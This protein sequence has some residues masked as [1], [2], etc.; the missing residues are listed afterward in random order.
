MGAVITPLLLM[1][2]VR[3]IEV[4]SLAQAQAARRWQPQAEIQVL[5]LQGSGL[6]LLR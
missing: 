2:K 5:W 6:S 4:I 3:R 1:R